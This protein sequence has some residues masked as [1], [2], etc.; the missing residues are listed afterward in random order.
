MEAFKILLMILIGYLINWRIDYMKKFFYIVGAGLIVGVMAAIVA[1][2]LSNKKKKKCKVFH[3]YKKSD[4]DKT[5]TANESL[6]K[7][8][9]IQEEFEYGDIKSSAVGSMYSR[10]EGAATVIKDSVDI[11]SENVKV[12]ENTNN[13]ID[14]VSAE[15]DKMLSED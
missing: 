12:F 10:H 5:Y 15:L 3:D 1:Y 2:L 4:D 9:P 11:I 6:I 13:E 8:A 14:E 7:T